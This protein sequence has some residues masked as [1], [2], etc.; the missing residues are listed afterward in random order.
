MFLYYTVIELLA[1]QYKEKA[2][3][4]EEKIKKLK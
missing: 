4:I 3:K 1:K 2:K